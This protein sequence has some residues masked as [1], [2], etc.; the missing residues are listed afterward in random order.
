MVYTSPVAPR[1]S[2]PALN[3]TVVERKFT[4]S[5]FIGMTMAL[6]LTVFLHTIM[7]VGPVSLPATAQVVSQ[8][9]QHGAVEAAILPPSLLE[10]LC[11]SPSS[12]ALIRRQL[13]YVYFGGAPLPKAVGALISPYVK[14]MPA[15]GS[16]EAGPYFV[17]V[18][19]NDTSPDDWS[20]YSFRPGMGCVF[21]P[22]TKTGLYELVFRRRPEYERW[23]QVFHVYPTQDEFPTKDLWAKHPTREGL[24]D[25]AGRTDDLV[26][27]SHGEDLH[28]SKMEATI[29]EHADVKA[30]LIGGEGRKKPFLILELASSAPGAEK[31]SGEG[32]VAPDDSVIDA[33]WPAVE[34]ANKLCSDYVQLSK[35]LTMLTSPSRPFLRTAKD[36]VARRDSLALYG[37]DI[38]ALYAK[39]D[40]QTTRS[41]PEERGKQAPDPLQSPVSRFK[42]LYL[43]ICRK[44]RFRS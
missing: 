5:Q 22:R 28:A 18:R 9:F 21:E 30:A 19:S 1:E 8:I 3:I 25:Y 4:K 10:D 41:P 15:I 35:P 34:K 27:L 32:P 16:T 24:W 23:Q 12:L 7:V 2:S 44:F 11:A 40:T 33:L 31:G 26:I 38:S 14:L 29:E 42:V 6:Q 20:Y 43:S 39:A 13:K 37:D 17:E 36:T